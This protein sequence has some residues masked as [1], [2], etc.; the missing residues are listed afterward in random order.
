VLRLYAGDRQAI[1]GSWC[2]PA[3]QPDESG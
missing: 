2:P 1:A 3:L